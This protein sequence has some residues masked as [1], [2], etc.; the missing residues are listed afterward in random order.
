MLTSFLFKVDAIFL[1]L[2]I[3]LMICRLFYKFI[4]VVYHQIEDLLS[5][6]RN[7]FSRFISSILQSQ[8][9]FLLHLPS[10]G[11]IKAQQL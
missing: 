6:H 11:G 5:K 1:P 7:S 2:I 3:P 4:I 9:I 10:E 8:N